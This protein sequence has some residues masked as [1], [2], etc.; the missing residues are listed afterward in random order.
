MEK[1]EEDIQN[2]PVRRQHFKYNEF[3]AIVNGHPTIFLDENGNQ[4]ANLNF[5][6][7][8]G[9]VPTSFL[10]PRRQ[11]GSLGQCLTWRRKG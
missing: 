3:S 6:P 10:L 8:E 5:A 11:A 9:K 1:E 7:A 4:T 2:D